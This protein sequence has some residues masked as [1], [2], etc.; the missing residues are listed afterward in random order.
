MNPQ[1]SNFIPNIVVI[2]FIGTCLYYFLTSKQ[3]ISL[4][5]ITVGYVERNTRP[6]NVVV[7]NDINTKKIDDELF[8]ECVSSL[9]SL[10]YNKRSAKKLAD[11]IFQKHDIQSTQQFIKLAFQEDV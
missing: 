9:H 6:F 2:I 8:Q 10:G 4:D 1:P 11:K 7:H 5:N 3:S